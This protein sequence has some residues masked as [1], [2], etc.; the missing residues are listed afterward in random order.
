LFIST[1]L[2]KTKEPKYPVKNLRSFL[3]E[4][5]TTLQSHDCLN[6]ALWDGYKL[7]RDV[8]QKLLAFGKAFAAFCHVPSVIDV[9]LVGGSA[10]YNWTGFSDIDVHVIA[11]RSVMGDPNLVDEFLRAK[12]SLW[13]MSRNVRVAGH[14]LE[15]YVQAPG[16]VLF[17]A[18]VYSLTRDVWLK[19]PVRN[20]H[21]W[22]TDEAFSSK[23]ENLMAQIDHMIERKSSISEF[24]ALKKRIGDMRK[25]GLTAGG[26][27]S[28][29]NAVFKELRNSGYL[30][31]MTK[32][33]RDAEDR[34]LSL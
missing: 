13:S 5:D 4:F 6:S 8:R 10:G 15:G 30:D 9:Q 12:K 7:K 16:E 24:E 2:R 23:V 18:G 17:S 25:S 3:L 14:P 11:D 28:V 19:K 34:D 32:Y 20:Q 33:V 27:Y 1:L 26:E 21:T 22:T 29:E 31:R